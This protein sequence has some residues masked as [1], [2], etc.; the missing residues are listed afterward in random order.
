LFAVLSTNRFLGTHTR[1]DTWTMAK[2]EGWLAALVVLG[3]ALYSYDRMDVLL[4]GYVQLITRSSDV[5]VLEGLLKEL[6]VPVRPFRACLGYNANLDQRVQLVELLESLGVTPPSPGSSEEK[7]S[8]HPFPHSQIATP[9]ELA[10]TAA[11]FF[12]KG[13]AAERFVSDRSFFQEI[14]KAA[15]NLKESV[16]STG[17]NAGETTW[18]CK[19]RDLIFSTLQL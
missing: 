4:S 12:S 19:H 8:G 11:Y 3:V 6:Q 14:V 13:S 9:F 2:W 7:G 16:Y 18:Y 1:L 15:A 17:G 10:E 5:R